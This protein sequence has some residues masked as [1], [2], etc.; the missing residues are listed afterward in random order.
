M[1]DKMINREGILENRCNKLRAIIWELAHPDEKRLEQLITRYAVNGNLNHDDVI[2]LYES[3]QHPNDI[4][5]DK[6]TKKPPLGVMPRDKWDKKRKNDLRDAIE[7]YICYGKFIP[8]EW[9]QEY[10]EICD[11]QEKESE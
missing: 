4:L 1:I 8:T 3:H 2:Y 5:S 6:K 10:N 11:R 9:I 7:R